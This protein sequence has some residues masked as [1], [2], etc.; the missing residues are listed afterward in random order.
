LQALKG[1]PMNAIT[2]ALLSAIF[3]VA[4]SPH[5]NAQQLYR[6]VGTDGRITYSDQPPSTASN[7]KVT[8]AR[9]GKFADDTAASNAGLPVE[10]RTAVSAYPATLYTS[11]NCEPCSSARALLNNRGIPFTEKTVNSNAD[12]EAFK[13]INTEAAV[14]A[15]SLGG[16]I[17]KGY[18]D[19][20]WNQ[21]LDAAN[22]PKNSVLPQN[23][24]NASASPLVATRQT[25]N[26]ASA[27]G[28]TD[29]IDA[30]DP[31]VPSKPTPARNP[32]STNPSGIKF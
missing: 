4:A 31:I 13:K 20:E 9:G 3:L 22:Y 14:P 29:A 5:A 8:P 28:S 11:K 30:S 25:T 19:Q 24:R 1:L 17:V 2:T 12:I 18:S 7:N 10:L 21:Y 15:L 27:A 6:I 23:Y 32:P 26:P 16:K